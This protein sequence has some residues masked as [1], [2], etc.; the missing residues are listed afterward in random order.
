MQADFLLRAARGV[1]KLSPYVPGKPVD[2]L[3]RELG[4]SDVIKLAS[5]ENPLGC[6]AL[7]QQTIQRELGEIARYPDGNGFIL[8]QALARHYDVDMRCVTLGNGSNDVLEIIARA[9]LDPADEAVYSQHAFAVYP[10][11]VQA[12]GATGITVPAKNYG[13]DLPALAAAL[14]ERS[15]IVFLANPNNPTGTWFGRDDFERFMQAVPAQVLVVLDEAYIEYVSDE[16]AEGMLDGMAL[17]QKYPNLIV[18]RTFSKAYGLASL[19]VGYAVSSPLIADVLNRVRQPFNVNSFAMAAATAA[20]SDQDFVRRSRE[21]NAAGM[22]QLQQ[23][24]QAMGLGWI[25]SAG[26][27]ITVFLARESMPVYQALLREGV[28]VRPVA[29]Y[30]LP[31][32]LRVSMGLP[33][34]NARFLDV[35]HKVMS[36]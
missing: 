10:L 6:S 30:G 33:V 24:L 34:E 8:R 36:A 18:T 28:I 7:V 16:V 14:T 31:Q 35:L 15:K 2:E 5:N 12:I 20:L 21:S 19:R 1:Q 29:N 27:F 23:G 22:Q 3:K 32:H 9:F 26:N 4:L 13:H 25:P 17:L 11:V